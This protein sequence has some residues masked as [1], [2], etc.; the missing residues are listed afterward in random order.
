[1]EKLDTKDGRENIIKLVQKLNDDDKINFIYE[2]FLEKCEFTKE[3]FFSNHK[4]DKIQA[5]CLLQKEMNI[6]SSGK[7]KVKG[8]MKSK[9]IFTTSKIMEMKDKNKNK[10][11]ERLYNILN[12]ISDDLE[13][14]NITKKNLEIFLNMSEASDPYVKDKLE[15]ITLITPKYNKDLRYDDYKAIIVEIN[16]KLGELKFIKDSLMIFHRNNFG[17]D[18]KSISNTLKEIDSNPVR[19]YKTDK[20][21]ER[22]NKLL[23]HTTLCNEIKQLKDFLL[24]KKIYENAMGKDKSDLFKNAKDKLENLKKSF[25]K[26]TSK[27][28]EVIFNEKEFETTFQIIK[29]ELSNTTENKSKDFIA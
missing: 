4:N 2:K 3:E 11:A 15:L 13:R 22:I 28:I 19:L 1:M 17:E 21:Q 26:N 25:A 9:E 27:N 14:E 23:I 24:F 8:D 5:L 10:F 20:I 29:E 12:Q 6:I 16:K 18:I 7:D